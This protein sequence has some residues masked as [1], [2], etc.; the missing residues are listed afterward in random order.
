MSEKEAIVTAVEKV[1][2]EW[3]IN[4]SPVPKSIEEWG[5]ECVGCGA[6]EYRIDGF[7]SCECRDRHDLGLE[8]REA[9][10]NA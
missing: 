9:I 4:D 7:C 3:G 10:R 8:I 1:F 2:R 5:P 6:D